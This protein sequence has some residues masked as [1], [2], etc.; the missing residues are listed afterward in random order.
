[1]TKMFHTNFTHTV[2]LLTTNYLYMHAT[3]TSHGLACTLYLTCDNK[4]KTLHKHKES[5]A[6]EIIWCIKDNT[7]KNLHETNHIQYCLPV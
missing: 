5:I 1:M 6:E 2:Q 4:P 7:G 3:Q